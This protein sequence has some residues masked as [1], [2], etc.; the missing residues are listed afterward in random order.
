[1]ILKKILMLGEIGV[2][3]TSISRRLSFG[4]FGDNYKATIGVDIYAYDVKPDPEG[5]PF[6]FLVWDT[7]GSHGESIFRQYYA[8]QAQAA[9]IVADITR[10]TTLDS[11]LK[12]GRLYEEVM[13]GRYYA[14]VLNKLD[15]AEDPGLAGR[16]EQLKASRVPLFRT[17]A[18]TGHNV[19][20]AFHDAAVEII[21]L[22]R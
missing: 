12:L 20:Q 1:M 15:L 5:L 19:A 17:S 2:G 3:K 4:T 21:R 6:K 10:P 18:L 11:M 8:R 9:M 22:E 7:D 14:F 16:L 13:P